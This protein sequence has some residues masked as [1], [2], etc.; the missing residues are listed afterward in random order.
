LRGQSD[1]SSFLST[2][3]TE[4]C[5]GYTFL[6]DRL[7]TANLPIKIIGYMPDTKVYDAFLEKKLI[8]NHLI[9]LHKKEI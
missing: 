7:R 9:Q 4:Y 5:V 3:N 2:I 1:I 8:P 6:E